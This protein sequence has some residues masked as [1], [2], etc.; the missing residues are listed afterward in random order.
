MIIEHLF[1]QLKSGMRKRMA[2]I[3][4]RFQTMDPTHQNE[5][6]RGALS[7]L[8]RSKRELIAE[9]M[10]LR[11]QLIVLVRQVERPRLTQQDRQILV[12]LAS[13]LHRWREALIVVK[14]D[15]LKGWHRQGF[16]LY[17]RWKSRVRQGRPPL[18][19]ETIALIEVMAINN[20]M[21][22]AKR[23]QGELLKLG[24]Y[25]S[26]ETIKRYV[27]RVRG[28]SPPFQRGQ[29]WATFLAN[30]AGETWACD[31]VQTYDVLFR[32]VFVYFIIELNSRRVVH[33]GVT[34]SPHDGGT[35]HG[36]DG[37]FQDLTEKGQSVR[38]H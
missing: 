3:E 7:D 15:T 33:Y 23:I 32:T 16:R 19:A 31:F 27:R 34:R 22:R 36:N 8:K 9:N 4:I 5:P 18:A 17:W 28:G 25:V 2:G 26:R 29:T 21:W 30:H 24:I 37:Q 38:L 13:Q 14:P 11:Q 12:L 6:D 20:R 1:S 35:V 10:F